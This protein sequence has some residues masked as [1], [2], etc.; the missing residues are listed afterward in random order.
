MSGCSPGL[1][2]PWSH[3]AGLAIPLHG[4]V[5]RRREGARD[6]EAVVGRVH[7]AVAVPDEVVGVAHA[8]GVGRHVARRRAEDVGRVVAGAVEAGGLDVRDQDRRRQRLLP[9]V[10]E[11]GV[12]RVV[13]AG[14]RVAALGDV[15]LAV[16]PEV[17]RVACVVRERA[18]KP[19]DDV[20]TS[21]EARARKACVTMPE[22]GLS[23]VERRVRVRGL[24][25]HVARR[26]RWVD[27]EAERQARAERIDDLVV[28]DRVVGSVGQRMDLPECLG[29]V[30]P[31]VRPPHHR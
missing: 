6:A 13:S 9:H 28:R 1:C 22:F 30:E 2:P 3:F 20:R 12:G 21:G 18:R 5:G 26:R 14:S 29:N 8:G 27:R 19:G 11:L 15:E 23:G 25:D 7:R 17:D 31:V 16:G 24:E 10:A 4:A